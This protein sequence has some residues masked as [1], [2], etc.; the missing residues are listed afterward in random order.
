MTEFATVLGL[1]FMLVCIAFAVLHSHRLGRLVLLDWTI[2]GMGGV[3]GL[4]WAV[5]LFVTAQGGNPTWEHW[6][7]PYVEFYPVHTLYAFLL[8]IAIIFG[9]LIVSAYIKFPRRNSA[10]L[11]MEKHSQLHM[12]C[13]VLLGIAIVLHYFYA[14]AYG[15]FI[16]LLQYSAEIRSSIF[17]VNNP[18]S[19]LSPFSGIALFASFGFFG[20]WIGQRRRPLI[21]VGML[22]SIT[23][24]LY[25]LYSWPAGSIFLF[26][27]LLLFLDM[28]FIKDH[29]L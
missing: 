14:R 28:F 5:V 15:G 9:W 19:F 4:G 18:L 16:G 26:M 6:I 10:R 3:Y 21:V 27:L 24:S 22:I 1:L 12:A 29:G 2:L 25:V 11:T 20:L 8:A 13:W 17:P 23:F 7:L